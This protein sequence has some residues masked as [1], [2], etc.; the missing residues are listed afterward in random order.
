MA[1]RS[2]EEAYSKRLAIDGLALIAATNSA[3]RG[4]G[5]SVITTMASNYAEWLESRA[6]REK[7]FAEKENSR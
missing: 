4:L 1:Y 6:Q 3:P 7:D 5:V 2:G